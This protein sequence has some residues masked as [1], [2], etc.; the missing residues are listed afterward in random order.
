[1]QKQLKYKENLYLWPLYYPLKI[2][3][4]EIHAHLNGNHPITPQKNTF[5]PST[6]CPALLPVSI[7]DAKAF[8]VVFVGGCIEGLMKASWEWASF[9]F[10]LKHFHIW[11]EHHL[12]G[13]TVASTCWIND[14]GGSKGCGSPSHMYWIVNR[15]INGVWGPVNLTT[16][17]HWDAWKKMYRLVF[18][19]CALHHLW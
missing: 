18:H 12:M 6:S 1:M 16:T 17:V 7:W 15:T 3:V 11:V 4:L 2:K 19:T 13:C 5:Q 10:L 8:L 14:L 9:T